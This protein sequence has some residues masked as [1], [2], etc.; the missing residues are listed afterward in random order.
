MSKI[1]KKVI[2]VG[3]AFASP[4]WHK[5]SLAVTLLIF[6]VLAAA[7][8][9][10]QGSIVLVQHTSQDAG[11]TTSST[12]AFSGNNTAGNWIAVVIRAGNSSS[13]VFTVTDS[14][15]NTYHQAVQLA[16]TIAG[17]T[18]GIFYAENVKGGPNTVMASDTISSPFR[19]AI[20]EYSGVATANS[21]DVTAKAQGTGTSPSSGNAT[22]TA[23]GDLLLGAVLST[24]AANF[25]AS[26][27][28]TIEAS[29]PAEPNSKLIVEDEIQGSAGMASASAS[30]RRF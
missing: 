28:Y 18:L 5:S 25:T 4:F 29:V 23:S 13:E 12:L 6:V 11:I 16:Q 8:G 21:L 26:S 30:L 9:H 7:L 20:M 24:N 2:A 22:T 19:L 3:K 15:K 17:E 14:N 10:A 1:L 27:G